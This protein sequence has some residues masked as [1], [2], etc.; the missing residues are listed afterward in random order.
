MQVWLEVVGELP[1]SPE[2]A[3]TEENLAD[4]IYGPFLKGLEYAHT[5][6]F[7]D[8]AAQRQ[9]IMDMTNRI[10]LEDQPVEESVA[11]AAE[12]EQDIIDDYQ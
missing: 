3:L 2:A 10:F 7:Y 4:P 12:E 9:V 8:E 11:E 6:T 5:T 1:A